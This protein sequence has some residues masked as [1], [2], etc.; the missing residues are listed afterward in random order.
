MSPPKKKRGKSKTQVKKTVRWI[1]RVTYVVQ[2]TKHKF[3]MTGKGLTKAQAADVLMN[4]F[5]KDSVKIE[6]GFK[7]VT[8]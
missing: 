6:A 8:I 1:P 2:G 4:V 5:G 7:R 3:L